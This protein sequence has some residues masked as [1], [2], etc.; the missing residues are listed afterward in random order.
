MRKNSEDQTVVAETIVGSSLKV[1]GDLKSQGDIRIDGEVRGS[2]LTDGVILVGTSAK[3]FASIKA[4]SAEIAGAVEGDIVVAKR[5]S[6][7]ETARV[8]GN[9]TCNELVIAQGAQFSGQSTMPGE[10]AENRQDV[11]STDAARATVA[12]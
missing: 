10:G 4:A 7:I 2:V 6:L 1:E 3:V 11:P 9:I 8:R 12:A 5:V